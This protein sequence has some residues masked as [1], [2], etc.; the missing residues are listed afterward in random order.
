MAILEERQRRETVNWKRIAPLMVVV[1]LAALLTGCTETA[2][3]NPIITS[4]TADPTGTVRPGAAVV[5]TVVAT[6]EDSDSLAFT[7]TAT[8]GILSSTAGETVTW[9]APNGEATGTVTVACSDG[10]GGEDT[11][12]TAVNSRAWNN[13]N[14]DGYTSDSTYLNNPGTS[15][16][17]F[18]FELDSDTFPTGAIA[19]SVFVTTDFEPI[20]TLGLEQFSVWVVSPSGITSLIYDGFNMTDLDVDDLRIRDFEGQSAVGAWKLRITR[21]YQGVEGYAD[22]CGLTVYYHW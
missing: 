9:T 17:T 5:L 10:Q 16:V 14:I 8:V 22:Q 18:E 7:W 11:A 4:L 20:D 2:N 21:T 3:H 15:E 19:E 12:F 13:Y 6:D 1:G